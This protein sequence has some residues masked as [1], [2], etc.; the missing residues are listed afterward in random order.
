MIPISPKF[1][2][3]KKPKCVKLWCNIR[4]SRFL[5]VGTA[6]SGRDSEIAPTRRSIN[7]NTRIG[8]KDDKMDIMF[9]NDL[10]FGVCCLQ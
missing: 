2:K 4:V 5:F 6:I 3:H 9:G 1:S 10:L 7:Y 8:E